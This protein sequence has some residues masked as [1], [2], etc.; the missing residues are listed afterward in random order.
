VQPIVG[1]VGVAV[2]EAVAA[3]AADGIEVLEAPFSSCGNRF[4]V[5]PEVPAVEGG[6]RG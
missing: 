4:H 6:I 2:A 5:A 3:G 1:E